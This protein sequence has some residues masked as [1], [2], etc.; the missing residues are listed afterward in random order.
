MLHSRNKITFSKLSEHQASKQSLNNNSG[1]KDRAESN[2]TRSPPGA[3]TNTKAAKTLAYFPANRAKL[4]NKI[5]LHDNH[6]N[7]KNKKY[8]IAL[9]SLGVR[10]A[11]SLFLDFFYFHDRSCNS[12]K[13]RTHVASAFFS[14][15]DNGNTSLNNLIPGIISKNSQRIMKRIAP[16]QL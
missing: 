8:N 4:W 12:L 9:N 13:N 1:S 5:N 2:T 7:N 15:N 16:L 3:C 14:L 10:I 6:Y 11:F